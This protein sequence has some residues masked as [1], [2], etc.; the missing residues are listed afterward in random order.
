MR[1]ETLRVR[2]R[3]NT[4]ADQSI[5]GLRVRR[6]PPLFEP[7]K[8]NVYEATLTTGARTNYMCESWNHGFCQLVGQ[9]HPSVW[10]AIE[11]IQMDEAMAST[12]LIQYARGQPPTKRVRR[13]TVRLQERLRNLC[14]RR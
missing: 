11:S 12:S 14:S 8:W 5:K 1:C 2:R 3:V 7:E 4:A 10:T 6:N 13:E 9:A